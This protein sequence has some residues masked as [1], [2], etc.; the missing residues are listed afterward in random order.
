M[1]DTIKEGVVDGK[2]SGDGMAGR[3]AS[4]RFFGEGAGKP[5]EKCLQSVDSLKLS[6]E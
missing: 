2:M 1:I 5:D 6:V 3:E 4:A